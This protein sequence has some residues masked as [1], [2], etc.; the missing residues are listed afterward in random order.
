LKET[1][2]RSAFLAILIGA[3][4]LAAPAVRA[5][6]QNASISEGGG[7]AADLCQELLAYAEMKAKEPP[8]HGQGQASGPAAAPLPRSD[9]QASGTQGGGSVDSSS[10]KDTG[11]QG[12]SAPPTA[13]VSSGAASEA[14]SSPHATDGSDRGQDA[15][16]AGAAVP[17]AEFRLAGG[18]TVAKVRDV[19]TNGERQACRDLAQTVRRGGGDM[20]AALIALAAYE[21]DPAKRK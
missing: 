20:P 12:G 5:Q 17:E 11:S 18:V 16:P 7:G 1:I 2:M 3:S 15:T 4:A 6:T 8:K 14:A 21:P 13:P 9:G 19:A 10:S